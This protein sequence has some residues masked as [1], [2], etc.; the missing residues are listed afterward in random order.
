MA[1]YKTDT[2][3][4]FQEV[5]RQFIPNTDVSGIDFESREC[6][7]CGIHFK[8][9]PTSEQ[10]FHNEFCKDG[11]PTQRHRFRKDSNRRRPPLNLGWK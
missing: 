8:C 4:F 10:R 6:I 1:K 3:P 11:G 2:D 7:G 9:L 5:R